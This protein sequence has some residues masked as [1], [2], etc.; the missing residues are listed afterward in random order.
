VIARHQII[1]VIC[2]LALALSALIIALTIP[3]R[4]NETFA[5]ASFGVP[6]Y[7]YSTLARV[8]HAGELFNTALLF[9]VSACY[10]AI[11]LA[12]LYYILRSFKWSL[13]LVQLAFGIVHFLIGAALVWR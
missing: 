7:V 12:P 13:V 5:L 9:V 10:L 11:L 4:I 8:F 1:Y 2:I 6:V 3:H